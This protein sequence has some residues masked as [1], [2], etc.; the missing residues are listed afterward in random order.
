MPKREIAKYF[1]AFGLNLQSHHRRA[2]EKSTCRQDPFRCLRDH[3]LESLETL[4]W[5]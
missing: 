5:N 2:K 3:E 4:Q 1:K